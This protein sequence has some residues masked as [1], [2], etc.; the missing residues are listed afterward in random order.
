MVDLGG[1]TI[2]SG[3]VVELGEEDGLLPGIRNGTVTGYGYG[4]LLGPG[5]IHNVVEDMTLT[6]NA[7]AGVH[8]FVAD[9]GRTGNT[10]RNNTF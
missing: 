5:T 4:V 6:L 1:H 7:I 3:L 10:V 2:T 8:F 9:D